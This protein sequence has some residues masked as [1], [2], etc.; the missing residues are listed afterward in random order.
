[1]FKKLYLGIAVAGIITASPRAQDASAV[2]AA[3]SRAMGADTLKTIEYSATGYDF[4]L[5]Q[6]YNPASAWPKF[7]NKTYTRALDFQVPASRVDRVRVQFENPPRGGG[8]QPIRGEQPQNQTIVIGPNTPWVQQL[9][10]WMTPYGFLKAAAMNNTTVKSQRAGGRRF[11]V[12]TFTGQNKA[13]VNGYIND[14]NMVERVETWIDDPLLGDMPFDAV[15]TQYKD[16]GGVKFPMKIVQNQGGFPIFDLDVTEVKPNAAVTI[17]SPQGRGGGAPGGAPGPAATSAVPI[18][19][20]GDG[21]YLI[22]GGYASLAV[23]FKDS[24]VVVEAGQGEDRSNAV[25]AETKKL[26]PNKPIK[27]LINTHHHIDHSRGLRTFVD[28]GATIVTHQINRPYFEKLFVAPH[29]LNPD[30]LATSKRR[31]TFETMTEK[32]V[33]TDGNRVIELYHLTG[34][35][36]NE[37]LLIVYFPKEKVLVEAD[38]YNPPAQADAPVPLPISPYTSNLADAIDRLKLD[39]D[40]IIPIH[41]PADGRKVTRAEFL[42]AAGRPVTQTASFNPPPA[43]IACSVQELQP[44]APKGSTITQARTTTVEEGGQ[45]ITYCAVDAEVETPGN[46]VRFRLGLPANW[47]GNFYF[48]G[49]GGFGGTIAGLNAGLSRGYASASTDTGHQGIATDASWGLNNPAK[50]LDY[51]HRGTHVTAVAAKGLSQAYYGSAPRH[52]Y[53]NGCSNGGR[54]A[55]MEAQRYPDDFDGL[56]A[57]DPALGTMGQIRRTLTYQAMLTSPDRLLPL[58]KVKLVADAVVA[59]CDGRDGLTDGLISDP[60]ACSFRPETLACKG[61]DAPD[62]L[63]AGQLETV[64]AV[65]ADAATPAGTLPGF[66]VGHEDGPTGWQAWVTGAAPPVPGADGKLAYAGNAPL[67]FRFQEGFLKYLAFDGDQP[68]DWRTFSFERDGARLAASMNMYSPTDPNLAALRKRGGKLILY[69]GWS[70]PGISATGTIGYYDAVTKAAGGKDKADEF[71]KLFM[72]PGMHHCQGNGPG[73]NTFDMLTALENWVERGT[74]PTRVVAKH[75]SVGIVDRTRPLC[76]Y[77]QA[78]RY[79]GTGSVDAA[80]SFRCEAPT[81]TTAS[82]A[83]EGDP[84]PLSAIP[85]TPWGDPD[86]QGTWTSEAELSVPFER[87][88]QYGERQFLTDQEFAQRRSQTDRQLASDNAEFDVATADTTNAGQVGSATS[89]PPHWLERGKTSR[90]TSLVIAPANGRVP[91]MTPE[92]QRRLRETRGGTFIGANFSNASFKGPEDLSLWE[93]C[94]SRGMPGAIFPTVYNANTRIVQAPGF[95][96]ITYEMIHDTRVIPLGDQPHA[97]SGVRSYFGDSRG[98]WEGDTLVVDVTNFSS[99]TNYRGSHE[100]LHLIERYSRT[101]DGLHYEV[102]VDDPQT[103]TGQWTAALDLT[104]QPE[105]M[106]EYA[107]HEGNN[108]MRNILSAARAAEKTR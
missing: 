59:S 96:A 76:A 23:D 73:P 62:C 101:S 55:L 29:T 61:A 82:R 83:T 90:R 69:H 71:V 39:V 2:I 84:R 66:P 105:G 52:A 72:V 79:T 91:S 28:E 31:A 100:T 94:I 5:G 30:R 78:A 20:L 107:C 54:Q 25:I 19:K 32:K 98:H 34:N 8:Q 9:E 81:V 13:Q 12:L 1:M 42:R 11:T 86:L 4:V 57:G 67:G 104:P 102:T 43:G 45:S 64:K 60:R 37:G 36:H 21:L 92:G 75:T 6:A 87:P 44:R 46:R 106:F 47:N 77:P 53:F 56:I 58:S 38:A 70:D 35:R 15:Y 3:A 17:Q 22:A 10:I 68:F 16:F 14:Q 48:E 103:W 49:V 65:Y 93:R 85:R 63:T 80:E 95:V 51:A 33:M 99:K 40:R 50:K 18:E 88:A 74:A 89:P 7:T 27:Y 97:G 26:I 24:I 41:L 108:S